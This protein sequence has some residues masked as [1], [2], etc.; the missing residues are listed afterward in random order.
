[1]TI[2]MMK[3]IQIKSSVMCIAEEKKSSSSESDSIS[4]VVVA[5]T[6]E[7]PSKRRFQ[8]IMSQSTYSDFVCYGML[9][10]SL[11]HRIVD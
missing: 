6:Y 5:I 11:S 1:M 3:T 4:G 7:P 10:L 8:M 2:V 9:I